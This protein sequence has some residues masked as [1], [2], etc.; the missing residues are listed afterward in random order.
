M[1]PQLALIFCKSFFYS[2]NT[3][4]L[5]QQNCLKNKFFADKNVAFQYA[6][7]DI[8]WFDGIKKATAQNETVAFWSDDKNDLAVKK[9]TQN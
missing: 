2:K 4:I 7:S 3:C 8:I 6:F 5:H 1:L 9:L